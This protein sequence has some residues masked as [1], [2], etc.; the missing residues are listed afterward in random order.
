MTSQ[1]PDKFVTCSWK[2]EAKVLSICSC[3]YFLLQG[4][5]NKNWKQHGK[6]KGEIRK[7]IRGYKRIQFFAKRGKYNWEKEIKSHKNV[8]Q[9]DS[10]KPLCIMPWHYFELKPKLWFSQKQKKCSKFI[11]RWLCKF[12]GSSGGRG[13]GWCKTFGNTTR[14]ESKFDRNHKILIYLYSW[15]KSTEK[16]K[17]NICY[18]GAFQTRK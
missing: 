12:R 5:W 4:K 6:E 18:F 13:G 1:K 7:S 9:S 16:T 11:I 14:F 2:N 3:S 10:R 15:K 8:D 17:S